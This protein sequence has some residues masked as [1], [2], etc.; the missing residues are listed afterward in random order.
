MADVANAAERGGWPLNT[1]MVPAIRSPRTVE[2][3]RFV[4]ALLTA[5]VGF[6]LVLLVQGRNPLSAYA[7]MFGST[8]GG[9]YGRTEVLVIVIPVL[10]CALAVAVPA[11]VGLVN[12]GAE[13]Q[14]Y[15]GAW[16]SSFVALTFT[17][18]PQ[19]VMLPLMLLMGMVG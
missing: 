9:T 5:L 14:L 13:G 1:L 16:A 15:L 19:L 7:D 12:V 17:Q 8:L 18:L 4:F 3:L 11:R 10:L 6:G 2:V